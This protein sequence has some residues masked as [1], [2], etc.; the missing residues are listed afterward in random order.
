MFKFLEK[1]D[2]EKIIFF[3]SLAFLIF[4]IIVLNNSCHDIVFHYFRITS[5]FNGIKNGQFFQKIYLDACSNYGYATPIFYSD[6][7][8]Y[9]P[10]I[11]L[12]LGIPMIVTYRIFIFIIIISSIF[13]MYFCCKKIFGKD[14]AKYSAFFY[15]FSPIMLNDIFIRGAIGE[16]IALIFIPIV[17][18]G[19]YSILRTEN[20]ICGIISLSL[21]M[22]G[23]ILSH[24]ISTVLVC[25]CLILILIIDIKNVLKNKKCIL[26]IFISAFITVLLTAYFIFPAIEQIFDSKFYVNGNTLSY[27]G[28]TVMKDCTLNIIDNFVSF[29]IIDYFRKLINY[30]FGSKFYF[31]FNWSPS[32]FGYLLVFLIYA[33]LKY[34][35]ELNNKIFNTLLYLTIFYFGLSSI[36]FI[37]P[38]LENFIGVIQFPWRNLILGTVFISIA[39]GMCIFILKYNNIK[40]YK[41]GMLSFYLGTIMIFMVALAISIDNGIFKSEFDEYAIGYAEYLPEEVPNMNYHKERGNIVISNDGEVN[42]TYDETNKELKYDNATKENTKFEFPLYMYKGYSAVDEYG[43]EYRIGKSS[44]GLVEVYL[45]GKTSGNI[46]VYYKGTDIQHISDT[47]SIVSFFMFIIFIIYYKKKKY[48]KF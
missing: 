2:F 28:I 44:N 22:S 40:D 24:I 15:G 11:M 5:V 8:L 27:P 46:K 18:C 41:L 47:I 23:I 35:R 3:S 48:S 31:Y 32:G 26:Y 6:L 1:Y 37:Q 21:G 29:T 43:K 20:I 39:G 12:C 42:F 17:F 13:T 9:I 45:D 10:A 30:I 25:F 19:F 16:A 33:K 34:K 7:F 4:S 36:K 14:V 38:L